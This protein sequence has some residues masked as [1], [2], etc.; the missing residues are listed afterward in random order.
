MEGA[1]SSG[2]G[3]GNGQQKA[4]LAEPQ[5]NVTRKKAR[6]RAARSAQKS[7]QA[8]SAADDDNRSQSGD[9][10]LA[11]PGKATDEA[12]NAAEGSRTT[13][14]TGR[15]ASTVELQFPKL[16]RLKVAPVADADAGGPSRDAGPNAT[17]TATTTASRT[18]ECVLTPEGFGH[19]C[20][21]GGYTWEDFAAEMEREADAVSYLTNIP[22]SP[23]FFAWLRMWDDTNRK[24]Q[25]S[26]L[27]WPEPPS[28]FPRRR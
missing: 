21:E 16:E 27:N 6:K 23:P 14:D 4:A 7:Q 15:E 19:W 24:S 22:S 11:S 13:D 25:A 1:T 28:K 2:D 26:P 3:Q 12:E 20:K 8:A 18:C 17:A 5:V 10:G 9:Q